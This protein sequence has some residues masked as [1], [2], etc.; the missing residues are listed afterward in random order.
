MVEGRIVCGDSEALIGEIERLLGAGSVRRG[1]DIAQRH[2]AD[3]SGLTPV[4]PLAVILPRS[5]E[6]VSAILQAFHRVRHPIVLQGGM[7]GAAG[8]GHPIDG[9]IVLSLE[10]LSGIEEIDVASATMTVLSGTPLAMIQAAATQAG[11]TCGIDLGAR[12]SATI[13]GIVSTNAGGNQ[14][15]RYGM[16]RRNVVG[17]EV[18]LADGSV[19]S[20][21]NKMPKNN[22]GYDWSQMFIGAEGTLGVVT[23]V[24]I[25]LQPQ[26]RDI[27]AALLAVDS[28]EAA[29]AALRLAREMLP[30]G[31]LVFEL[32]WCEYYDLAV[33]VEG[34]S[35]P[36]PAGHDGYVLVE[37]PGGSDGDHPIE[38][39]LTKA[40]EE[41]LVSDAIIAK[42]LSERD[43]FWALRES[44]YKFSRLIAPPI[45][46]DISFPLD[47][48]AEAIE[49]MRAE[50]SDFCEDARWCV[51]GHLGDGN[52]H[53]MVMTSRR[54][55]IKDGIDDVIYAITARLGGSVSGEHGIGRVKR[56]HLPLSRSPAEIDLMRRIK[57]CLDPHG[58][59][60]PGRVVDPFVSETAE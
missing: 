21:L 43:A 2:W 7:T 18:V 54:D 17:L 15:V 46:Y 42:S 14:V 30:G 39:W 53:V 8:G 35:P 24:V 55:E 47:R 16:A 28:T 48:M 44:A 60:N 19:V 32:M 6:D 5:V 52:V 9:E 25:T 26:M 11:Y 56:K 3:V 12:D 34:V 4:R 22:T 57:T 38:A 20:G 27:R 13:G 50:I 1:D 58:L 40:L 31:L 49:A 29:L 23:R 37:V 10:R 45:N 36:L 59:L 41:G 33:S 51:F